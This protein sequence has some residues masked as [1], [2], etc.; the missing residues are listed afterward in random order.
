MERLFL[1]C[2]IRATLLVAGTALVLYVMRVKS[3][4]A[5]HN[6]WTGVLVLMLML[7]MWT[8]WGPKAPVRVLPSITEGTASGPTGPSSFL[9]AVRL[10]A[11]NLKVSDTASRPPIGRWPDI[12]LGVYLLGILTLLVRLAIGTAK[13]HTLV[14][15]SV[16]RDGMRTS[17]S[18]TAP[19]TTGL[20]R[21]T[22]I[23]PEYWSKWPPAQLEA[24]LTHEGEHARRRDPLIQWLALFNRAVFW[25]H[26]A[27]W[28]LQRE[29][30]ELAEE[31]CDSAVLARGHSPRDYSEY[32]VDIARTVMR[33]GARLNTV[34]MAMPGGFLPQRVRRIMECGP[35]QRLSPVRIAGVAAACTIT[36]TL[37][38]AGTLD[39]VRRSAPEWSA[40]P[41][42]NIVSIKANKSGDQQV[43]MIPQRG[44]RYTVSNVP[45]SLLVALAYQPLQRFAMYGMPD[46]ADSERFDIDVRS[47]GNATREQMNSTLQSLL[48]KRFRLVVHHE[49]RQLSVYTLVALKPE[50]TGWRLVPHPYG[51]GCSDHSALS[52][53]TEPD[54]DVGSSPAPCGG[55]LMSSSHL[56]GHEIPMEML[57]A[58][59]S[60][61]VGRAVID[62]TGLRGTFD[63]TLEWTAQPLSDSP[64]TV[65]GISSPDTSSGRP[66]SA[67]IQEQL[68]LK[69]EPQT[70]QFDVLVIDHVEL[71]FE[72]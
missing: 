48:A 57:A 29:L 25:F 27:A 7:P 2:A 41:D 55:F 39:H 60:E 22:V 28:W 68:G 35:A 61:L 21:P 65:A 20:L 45:L 19:V 14:R 24:V 32:L 51:P 9:A 23:L 16:L 44:G 43:T 59:L 66:L 40:K 67:A 18:C 53:P 38:A 33:S 46:W 47:E 12:L 72:N 36:C 1:E 71:P 30:S 3:A 49:I 37:F 70:G 56:T 11:T 15:H 13:A 63:L 58:Q 64:E 5:K 31:A 34:G 6:S 26:P 52:T 17:F 62:R 54:P 50:Q 4:A 10:G 8:A 42:F 69:L